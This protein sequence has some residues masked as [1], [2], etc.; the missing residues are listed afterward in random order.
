MLGKGV[1]TL[2]PKQLGI[3]DTAHSPTLS[4]ACLTHMAFC[5]PLVLLVIFAYL[6][7]GI[8]VSALE[9]QRRKLKGILKES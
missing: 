2:F 3:L 8:A 9:L 4:F 1:G 5:R 6:A 7:W